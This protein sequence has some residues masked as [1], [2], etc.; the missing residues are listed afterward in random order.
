MNRH[1]NF[2]LSFIA[3]LFISSAALAL[4]QYTPPAGYQAAN[5]LDTPA[6]TLIDGFAIDDNGEVYYIESAYSAYYPASSSLKKY[7]PG[8]GTTTLYSFSGGVFGAF[9]RLIGDDVWFGE[10]SDN[11]IRTIPKAGGTAED[12]IELTGQY[13]LKVNSNGEIFATANPGGFTTAD[14]VIY[15]LAYDDLLGTYDAD[16]IA[17]IGGYSGPI[18][19]D[20]ADNLYYGFPNYGAGEVVYFDA[21]DV[22]T[23]VAAEDYGTAELGSGDWTSYAAGLSACGYLQFDD[24]AMGTPDL[25]SSSWQSVIDRAYGAGTFDGFGSSPNF[26]SLGQMAFLPGANDFEPYAAGSGAL[27]LVATDYEDY[28]STIFEITGAEP[29]PE[30]ATVLMTLLGLAATARVI[31]RRK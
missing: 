5:Y 13:D 11:W 4:P 20:A 19:F 17:D 24:D 8:G 29:V 18:E 1:I 22:A 30:P 15:Y 28:T 7:T 27:Y 23:A 16:L 26:S 21:A 2:G 9:V 31:T 3:L 25:F 14:S 12:I 10:S 6:G